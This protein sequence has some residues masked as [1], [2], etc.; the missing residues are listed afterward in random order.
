MTEHIK[1]K[2]EQNGTGRA[3]IVVRNGTEDVTAGQAGQTAR[4]TTASTAPATDIGF[5]AQLLACRDG[6]AA[7]RRHRR[8]EPAVATLRYRTSTTMDRPSHSLQPHSIVRTV[9]VA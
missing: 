4:Q 8:E 3:L 2:S 6:V 1:A 9:R 7:Y 5:L